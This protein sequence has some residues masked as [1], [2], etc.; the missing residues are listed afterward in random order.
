MVSQGF[1]FGEKVWRMP[2]FGG[3]QESGPLTKRKEVGVKK[4]T[5]A[6]FAAMIL[7]MLGGNPVHAQFGP[8]TYYNGY[9]RP[10][11]YPAYV[12][13]NIYGGATYYNGSYQPLVRYPAG[14]VLPNYYGGGTY[15]N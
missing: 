8:G 15:F 4:L 13:P 1:L 7:L 11:G 5:L 6:F 10:F 3:K 14:Y 12:L 9:Y 2:S